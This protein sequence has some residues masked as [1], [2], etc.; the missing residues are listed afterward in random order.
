MDKI[1]FNY[2]LTNIL[3]PTVEAFIQSLFEKLESF[4]KRLRCK[5]FFLDANEEPAE[6]NKTFGFTSEATPLQHNGLKYSE[7]DLYEMVHRIQFRP[8][9][10]SFQ[11]QHLA[12]VKTI[13]KSTRVIVQADKTTNLYRMSVADYSKLLNDIITAKCK[14]T[15]A[16]TISAINNEAKTIVMELQLDCE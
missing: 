16:D 11:S 14:K 6:Y 1:K 10:S 2:S 3:I 12:D 9:K 8:V 4:I 7:Q 13:R 15:S 5:A